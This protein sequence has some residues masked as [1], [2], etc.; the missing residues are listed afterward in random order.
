MGIWDKSLMTTAYLDGTEADVNQS[1]KVRIDEEVIEVSYDD[2]GAVV[3][4]GKNDNTGHFKL[5]CSNNAGKASLHMFKNDVILEGYWTEEGDE[6]FWRIKLQKRTQQSPMDSHYDRAN[7]L[8][9]K[10]I[11]DEVPLT[12]DEESELRSILI[13]YDRAECHLDATL[14]KPETCRF[15]SNPEEWVKWKKF[16]DLC[17]LVHNYIENNGT[18]VPP[19]G[20]DIMSGGPKSRKGRQLPGSFESNK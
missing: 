17:D 19:T 14:C 20:G 11:R 6:G 16:D 2:D 10:K 13:E 18:I 4:M 12:S 5:E 15:Y 1:C 8:L 3:Y 7:E 9:R